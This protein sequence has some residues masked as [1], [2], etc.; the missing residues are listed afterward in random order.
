LYLAGSEAAGADADTLHGAIL[1]NAHALEI[2]IEL[3]R[4][5]IVRVRNR[6]P[7]GRR[8]GA[9][10][11]LHWHDSLLLKDG[12]DIRQCAHSQERSKAF[13]AR[14]FGLRMAADENAT[15]ILEFDF[16]LAL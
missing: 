4:P 5:H 12:D 9:D 11:T 6:T 3:A 1:H 16:M 14:G 13:V 7:E 8:L 15:G 10:I 2:G